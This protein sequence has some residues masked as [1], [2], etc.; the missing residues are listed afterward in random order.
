MRTH[1][2][3]EASSIV[4]LLVEAGIEDGMA[5]RLFTLRNNR[6][7]RRDTSIHFDATG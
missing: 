2:S 4:R 6:H 5:Y 1:A 7:A 3:Y